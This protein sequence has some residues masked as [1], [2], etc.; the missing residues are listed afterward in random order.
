VARE[1][2]LQ[3]REYDGVIVQEVHQIY[4]LWYV[5]FYHLVQIDFEY[6]Y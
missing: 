2:E 3:I 6:W 4:V 1:D 5:T